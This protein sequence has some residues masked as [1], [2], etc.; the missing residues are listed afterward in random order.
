[1]S[2]R[3]SVVRTVVALP[4]IAVGLVGVVVPFVPGLPFLILGVTLIGVDH[5]L[6]RPARRLIERFRR[7]G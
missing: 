5:P 1:V 6:V 2:R 7:R 4:L 3:K